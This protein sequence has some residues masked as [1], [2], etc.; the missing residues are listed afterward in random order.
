MAKAATTRERADP[1]TGTGAMMPM[2]PGEAMSKITAALA[3]AIGILVLASTAS[4]DTVTEI[5]EVPLDRAWDAAFAALDQQ[6]GVDEFD[7][8]I[9]VLVSKTHRL[10]DAGVWIVMRQLRVRLRMSVVPVTATQV[11]VS[12]QRELLRR[13]RVL[14]MEKDERVHQDTADATYE[15]AVMRA[16]AARLGG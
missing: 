12:V 7:R 15:L 4:G 14:W 10:S 3:V 5:F 1:S 13:E 11:R 6:W 2:T 9:G 16:I 8:S